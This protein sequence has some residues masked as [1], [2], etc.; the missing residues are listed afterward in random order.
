MQRHQ[1]EEM[2]SLEAAEGSVLELNQKVKDFQLLLQ[3]FEQDSQEKKRVVTGGLSA[4]G[5]T[6]VEQVRELASLSDV[7]KKQ[8]ELHTAL[9]PTANYDAVARSLSEHPFAS[10]IAYTQIVKQKM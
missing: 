5:E 8:F 2:A 7:V 6:L 10:A 3:E 4:L 1:M 9:P